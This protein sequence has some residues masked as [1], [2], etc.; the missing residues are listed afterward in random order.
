MPPHSYLCDFWREIHCHSDHCALQWSEYLCIPPQIHML[1]SYP[2]CDVIWMQGHWEVIRS[3]GWHLHKW[4]Q[5]P[6]EKRRMRD[7]LS[8]HHV[9]SYQED[10]H[11]QTWKRVCTRTQPC[12]HPDLRLPSLQNWEINLCCL[13]HP[14]YG[15]LLLQPKQREPGRNGVIQSWPDLEVPLFY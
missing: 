5:W 9:R 1:K 11:L 6:S 2:Q 7:H 10:I 15:L 13:Y 3:W 12:W 8:L 4:D 14:V